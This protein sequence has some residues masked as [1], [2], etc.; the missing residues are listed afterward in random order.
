MNILVLNASPKGKNSTTVHT[1]LYLQAL[2]PEHTFIFLPVGQRI[3][4][5]EK[6]FTPVRTA[7]EQAELIL[8][9]Y[10][11]YTFIAPYQLHR[12]IE[13]IKADGVDL[14]GKFASQI[15]T[16]KHFYDVTAH[17][18]VEENCFDLGMK[19]IRGLSADME[20]LLTEQGRKEARMFF[21]QLIFS[22][23]HGPFATPPVQAPAREQ[24]EYQPAL[25]ETPKRKD[26]DVVIVT[27]CAPDDRNLRNMISDF[28]AALPCESR[29]VNIREFP[30]GGGCLGCFGCAITGKCVY[31]DGFD[32]FLRQTIQTADGFVYAFTISDHYTHSS[33]KCFDD[34]QFCNGHRTVTHGTPIA[35]LISGDYRYEPNLRMIVEGRAEVG[36]NYLCGVATDE[37]DTA[38]DIRGLAENLAFAMEHKLTRPANFYGVGG[39]KIFRDLIYV[40]QGLMKADHKF[41]KANGIYDFPQK[42]QKRIW[43][44]R[45][46]GALMAIPSIQKKAKGKMTEA[47][48]G[49]YQKVVEQAARKEA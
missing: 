23:A 33:F 11:V 40:M 7:L 18:Y 15:T 32:Q 49:P 4:A 47:M 17:R 43:Q 20:D 39:M 42:Q 12:L 45:L 3:K 14:S 46:V 30:F 48:I 16:S 26:K 10:P 44:M 37:G 34:R 24:A 19:V 38:A 6:D 9:C 25:P 29:V 36:G 28:R 13:L 8:F 35:Y 31:K 1:A 5:C 22:C 21:D 27:N 2:H 41:Y